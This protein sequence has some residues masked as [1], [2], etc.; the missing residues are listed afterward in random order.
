M[1][2]QN[3][4]LPRLKN[5]DYSTPGVYF[6]T[7]CTH[8]KKCIFGR[9]VPSEE[10]FMQY[11]PIGF[12]VQE[13]ILSIESYYHNIK[14]NHWV[15]M[16]NHVHLL[17]QITEPTT[18]VSKKSYSIPNVIGNFKS[19]VTREVH[20]RLPYN[21]QIWQTSYHDHVVESQRN[22]EMIWKYISENPIRWERDLF[23]V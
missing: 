9:I 2:L 8:R 7:I 20:K 23:Y 17:V 19:S 5:Y 18:V 4:K 10:P 16:P 11:S 13:C 3:R 14:I 15:I 21:G 22:Y 1:E 12:I 6:I